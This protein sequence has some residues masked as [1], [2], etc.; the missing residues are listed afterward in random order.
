MKFLKWLLIIIVLIIAVVTIYGAT[1]SPQMTVKESIDINAPASLV[2]EEIRDFKAWDEWSAW[3]KMDTVMEQ[4][5]EGEIGTVGYNNSWNIDNQIVGIGSQEIVDIR[6][7]EYMKTKM[8]FNGSLDENFASFTLTETDGVTTVVWDM[9]GA[10]TPFYARI[11]NT[12]FKPMIVESYK[13]SL[14][15]LKSIV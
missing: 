8:L 1:Q 2:F 12:I 5:Y 6:E 15:N 7:D 9:L 3:S 13:S 14:K 4:S 11:M 10:E